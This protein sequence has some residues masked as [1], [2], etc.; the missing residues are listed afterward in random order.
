MGELHK[1]ERIFSLRLQKGKGKPTQVQAT[2]NALNTEGQIKIS[3]EANCTLLTSSDVQAIKK[4]QEQEDLS[5]KTLLRTLFVT[6]LTRS[7]C[8]ENA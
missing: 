2:A 1:L 5:R 6:M 3:E 4:V 7:D 8:Q